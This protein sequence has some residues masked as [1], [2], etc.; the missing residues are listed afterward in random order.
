MIPKKVPIYGAYKG[1]YQRRKIFI[2]VIR[3]LQR[4][5]SGHPRHFFP[6]PVQVEKLV[7]LT[8]QFLLLAVQSVRLFLNK[9][10][11]LLQYRSKPVIV[12]NKY[13]CIYI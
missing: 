5:K 3:H 10:I 8:A 13:R 2:T 1:A 9:Y 6:F 4:Q 12:R 11:E 7:L